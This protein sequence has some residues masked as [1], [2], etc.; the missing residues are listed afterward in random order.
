MFLGSAGQLVRHAAGCAADLVHVPGVA[1]AAGARAVAPS[2]GTG[3]EVEGRERR[4][5]VL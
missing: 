5:G 3:R 4:G 2:H 1:G